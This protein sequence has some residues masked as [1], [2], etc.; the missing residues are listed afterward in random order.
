MSFSQYRHYTPNNCKNT[1]S[2]SSPIQNETE[3]TP[4][5]TPMPD[6]IHCNTCLCGYVETNE[7][8]ASKDQNGEQN[9][10]QKYKSVLQF[11]STK[12]KLHIKFHDN[13][14]FLSQSIRNDR[15][16]IKIQHNGFDLEIDNSRNSGYDEDYDPCTISLDQT[17]NGQN[18]YVIDIDM[19]EIIGKDGSKIPI[20]AVS[21][22]SYHVYDGSLTICIFGNHVNG[23]IK[24]V[25]FS[26]FLV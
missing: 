14:Q 16:F 8:S 15:L 23:N 4:V 9:Y 12:N 5:P 7:F 17:R 11:D 18:N 26:T 21:K 10:N 25:T 20:I 3:L 19:K 22:G 2:S 13:K 6:H 1:R 24:H